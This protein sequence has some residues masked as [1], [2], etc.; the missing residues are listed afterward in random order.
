MGDTQETLATLGSKAAGVRT[1]SKQPTALC[2][3]CPQH[4][5]YS[6]PGFPPWPLLFWLLPTLF[7][8]LPAP[9]VPQQQQTWLHEQ[10]GHWLGNSGTQQWEQA[11]CFALQGQWVGWAQ[12]GQSV[13][14]QMPLTDQ[15]PQAQCWKLC[16]RSQKPGS[17]FYLFIF[18]LFKSTAKPL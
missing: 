4:G 13:Q 3:R 6:V 12:S 7:T 17:E 9:R 10:R 18:F 5:T 14:R 16:S 2:P 11:L 1:C 8:L 15:K